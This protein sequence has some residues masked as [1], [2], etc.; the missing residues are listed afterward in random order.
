M[1]LEGFF[2]LGCRDTLCTVALCPMQVPSLGDTGVTLL[3][4]KLV[5]EFLVVKVGIPSADRYLVH[6]RNSS[7]LLETLLLG[8]VPSM[9]VVSAK[10]LRIAFLCDAVSCVENTSC[11]SAVHSLLLFP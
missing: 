6:G 11:R 5:A 4:L 10:F 7:L 3:R 1:C 2:Y 9:F 8:N